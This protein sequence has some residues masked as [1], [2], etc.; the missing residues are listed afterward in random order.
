[1]LR[2]AQRAVGNDLVTRLCLLRLGLELIA[3]PEAR[4][5]KGVRRRL[6]VDLLAQPPD[7]DVDRAVAM[8]FA[9]PPDLL[10]KLIARDDAATIE[11]EG[12]EELELGRR[13]RRVLPVDE[14]LHLAGIDPQLLD[15]D[16]VAAAILG[17]PDAT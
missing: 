6:P 12:I 10:Q 15:L 3:D 13:Q 8:R 16:R 11:R 2:A 7:E 9:A 17:R 1:M 5:D 14:C 4:L